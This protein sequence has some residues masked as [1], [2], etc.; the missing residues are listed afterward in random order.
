MENFF[1]IVHADRL[2]EGRHNDYPDTDYFR[3]TELIASILE[4]RLLN[5]AKDIISMGGKVFFMGSQPEYLRAI[6]GITY[7]PDKMG[8]EDQFVVTANL[9]HAEG[10]NSVLI[11]GIYSFAC[12]DGLVDVELKNL[13]ISAEVD[14]DLTE[15]F[16]DR[17]E[18]KTED[19]LRSILNRETRIEIDFSISKK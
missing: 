17:F 7:I 11:G 13:G 3:K 2:H 12:I 6:K 4:Q 19:D 10:G 9:I 18:L 8:G 15:Q 14:P 5:K 1:V 16:F